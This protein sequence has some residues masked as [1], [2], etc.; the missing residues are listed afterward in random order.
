MEKNN[1]QYV[2]LHNLSIIKPDAAVVQSNLNRLVRCGADPHAI[3]QVVR[4]GGTHEDMV[5]EGVCE[6]LHVELGVGVS[7]LLEGT[8]VGGQTGDV[9]RGVEGSPEFGAVKGPVEG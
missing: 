3:K 8:G 1:V 9:G 7:R 2:R 4:V 6:G 5:E